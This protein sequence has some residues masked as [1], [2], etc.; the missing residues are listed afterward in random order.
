MKKVR[1]SRS[2]TKRLT[3]QCRDSIVQELTLEAKYEGIKEGIM[4]AYQ[5]FKDADPDRI[6]D[7]IEILIEDMTGEEVKL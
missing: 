3:V 5:V 6:K 4:A 2:E 1:K 7:E